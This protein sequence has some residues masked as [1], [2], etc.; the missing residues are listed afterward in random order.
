MQSTEMATLAE[1]LCEALATRDYERFTREF[2]NEAIFEIPF[3]PEG[4][5]ALKGL[6]EIEA[7]FARVAASPLGKLIQIEK[8]SSV[9]HPHSGPS[10]SFTLEYFVDGESV[11]TKERFKIQSSI[12][13]IEVKDGKIVRYKDFPNTLGLVAAA[14]I[15]PQFA[16]GLSKD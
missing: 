8:I 10:D 11:R 3:G 4:G 14:G 13:V 2:A 6:P 9:Q 15:L 12:A 16:A 5:V 7:H 1:R